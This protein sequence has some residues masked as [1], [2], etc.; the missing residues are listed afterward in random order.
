[1][2]G[3]AV[4]QV[5]VE[6][7]GWNWKKR[8]YIIRRTKSDNEKQNKS[9]GWHKLVCD[10]INM[11]GESGGES[12]G[13]D[14]GGWT[15]ASASRRKNARKRNISSSDEGLR[16]GREERVVRQRVNVDDGGLK[17]ILKFCEGHDIRKVSPVALSRGL[18]EQ[19]GDIVFARVLNDGA[20]LIKCK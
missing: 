8:L 17:V 3:A 18:Y 14:T 12:E 19:L 4:F 15:Q 9:D 20:L 1:M 16:G 6:R 7:G 11:S 10:W 2:P 13:M 5:G